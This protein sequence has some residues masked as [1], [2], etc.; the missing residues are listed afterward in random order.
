MDNRVVITGLGPVTVAGTGK[1]AFW[2]ALLEKQLVVEPIPGKMREAYEYKTRYFVP[3]PALDWAWVTPSLRLQCSPVTLMMMQASMLAVE[4]AGLDTLP[5]DAAVIAGLGMGDLAQVYAGYDA[6]VN[7]TRLKR[8]SIPMIM[9]NA[10]AAQV[11]IHFGLHG[12]CFTV[13]AACASS[14]VAIGEAYRRIASG[15]AT[16]ALAGG[17]ESLGDPY[18]LSLRGF[19]M[20]GALTQSADGA[21]MPFDENRSGFLMNM[22]AACTLVLEEYNRAVDRG[23]RIY[24]EIVGYQSSCDGHHIV[25]MA[26][27]G[28][29]IQGMLHKLCGGQTVDYVNAHGTGTQPND[30]IEAKILCELFGSQAAQ[31]LVNSTKGILGHS[32]GASGALEAAATALTLSTG[33][34]HPNLLKNP[35]PGLCLPTEPVHANPQTALS[36]SYGFGGHNAALLFR[37]V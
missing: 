20:L 33:V 6:H 24:A 32:I 2:A 16:A 1:D 37:K 13:N 31:P 4:D 26:P 3:A 7:N 14:T 23:A 29:V 21:P 27:D 8:M 22:G 28:Q 11:S 19:D 35:M 9:P 5:A 34:V 36:A 25:Q 10:A 12:E 17:S 30:E 18:G 15:Q